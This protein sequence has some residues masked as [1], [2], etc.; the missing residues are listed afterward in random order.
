[1]GLRG[2]VAA[3]ADLPVFVAGGADGAAAFDALRLAPGVTVVDSPRAA[4]LLVVAGRLTRAL[5]R[6]LLAVHDQVPPPR[7]TVRWGEGRDPLLDATLPMAVQLAPGDI[8]GLRRVFARLVTGDHP[9]EPPALLDIEPNEWRGIGPYGTGGT[10]MTGGVPFGRPLPGRAPDPD[11]LELDQLPIEIGPFFPGLPPGLVLRLEVQGDVVRSAALG[12]N[13]FRAW[14]GDELPASGNPSPFVAALGRPVA[15]GELE[16][17][18]GRHHLRAAAMAVELAGLGALARRFRQL[19]SDLGPGS[20]AAV[21]A[22]HRRVA[23]SWSLRST[24]SHFGPLGEAAPPGLLERAR[25]GQEDA[26]RND[27]AYVA[28]GF[29]PIVGGQ[30]DPWGRLVQRLAEAEQA[31]DLAGRAGA[32]VRP[33]GPPVEGPR[34]PLGSDSPSPSVALLDRLPSVLEGHEWGDALAT[35]V[36][37]DVDL[38]EVAVAEPG[39]PA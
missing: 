19:A 5:L 26:R 29:E 4:A 25:G 7:A 3:A 1:M 22:A 21:A 30:D 28:L 31:V 34:G 6:P 16:V 36:S 15:L 18:R 23:R 24:L 2:R 32:E 10:G 8:D 13:P 39:V 33:P 38:E 37:L 20:G 35:L 17:A 14:P 27:P 9:S 11:G 12:P